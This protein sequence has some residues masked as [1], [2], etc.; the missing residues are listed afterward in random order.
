MP[1]NLQT[2]A[3]QYQ[4]KGAAGDSAVLDNLQTPDETKKGAAGDSAVLDNLQTP[5]EIKKEA[6]GD[7]AVLDNLQTPESD[8]SVYARSLPPHGPRQ[9]PWGG[10]SFPLLPLPLMGRGGLIGGPV[11]F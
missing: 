7:S 6:A 2:P 11:L 4:T 3:R 10:P 1:D 8:A 9:V 5:Y